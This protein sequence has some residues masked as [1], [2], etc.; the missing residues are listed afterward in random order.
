MRAL[1]AYC[2][3]VLLVVGAI[4]FLGLRTLD[5]MVTQ[6]AERATNERDA[7][8]KA[9]IEKSNADTERQLRFQAMA[10]QA[11]DAVAR[12]KIAAANLRILELE[13]D[14]EALPENSCGGLGRDRVKLLA[15]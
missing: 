3:T 4:A 1:I 7:H 14:N 10:A 9:E 15:R 6:S 2:A 8:W 12:D 5:R 13:K 11:A